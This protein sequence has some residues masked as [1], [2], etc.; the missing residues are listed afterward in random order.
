MIVKPLWAFNVWKVNFIKTSTTINTQVNCNMLLFV[1]GSVC[2][3]TGWGIH[4][5]PDIRWCSQSQTFQ[6]FLSYLYVYLSK[7]EYASQSKFACIQHA[8]HT[9]LLESYLSS[10]TME[11]GRG[12]YIF[13]KYIYLCLLHLNVA[14]L[15]HSP[16]GTNY[17]HIFTLMSD[18]DRPYT[19]PQIYSTNN[20]SCTQYCNTK[21]QLIW[22][23]YQLHSHIH[24]LL[25]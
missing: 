21:L 7:A 16:W 8:N 25:Y 17:Y 4:S 22:S 13:E 11:G 15:L 2:I 12:P 18:Q 19:Q 14:K 6:T 24:L 9:Q 10:S 23:I 1:L 3:V 5:H 20:T